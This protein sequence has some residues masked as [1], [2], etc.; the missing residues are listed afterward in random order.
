[1][2][3][4]ISFLIRRRAQTIAPQPKLLTLQALNTVGELVI[5]ARPDDAPTAYDPKPSDDPN[6]ARNFGYF[7]LALVLFVI[8]IVLGCYCDERKR[9]PKKS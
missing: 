2:P 9:T 7:V 6:S 3:V 8:L 4:L 1:M 5:Q